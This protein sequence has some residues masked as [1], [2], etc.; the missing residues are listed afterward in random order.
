M[1]TFVML[2]RVSPEAVHTPKELGTLERQAMD[3]IHAECPKVK[4]MAS[5]ALLGPYDY[6]DIFTAPDIE[7]ATKVS[8]IMR[9]WGHAYSEVCPAT[10]WNKFKGM[11]EKLRKAA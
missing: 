11:I 1:N 4:W 9:T 8:T 6:L 3:H 5:Y 2:T 7:T 10:E